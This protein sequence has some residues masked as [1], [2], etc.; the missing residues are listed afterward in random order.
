MDSY[1]SAKA[2]MHIH[3]IYSERPSEWI[4]K[5]LGT[6][7]SYTGP[8]ALYK[9]ARERGMDFVTITDHNKIDGVLLLQKKYPDRVFTGVEATTYFPED[10]C[11]IHILIYGFTEQQFEEIDKL[12]SDIYKL[13]EY[14]Y[15]NNLAYSVAH[16]SYAVNKKLT[17]EHIEKLFLMFDSFE[18]FNGSRA[19]RHTEIWMRIL[20]KLDPEVINTLIEKHGIKPYGKKP[21]E[22][23]HTGGTDDHSGLFPGSTYTSV[24]ADNKESFLEQIKAGAGTVHGRHNQYHFLAFS[25][26][27]I[28]YEYAKERG[29]K[30]PKNLLDNVHGVIFN[31]KKLKLGNKII[32]GKLKAGLRKKNEETEKYVVD[33]IIKSLQDPNL[34]LDEKLDTSYEAISIFSDRF[35]KSIIKSIKPNKLDLIGTVRKLSS[36]FFGLFLVLPF[37]STMKHMFQERQILEEMENKY[38]GEDHKKDKKILWFSDTLT[39]VNGVSFTLQKLAWLSFRQGRPLTLVSSLLESE[40]TVNLPP[41]VM[42]L[43]FIHHVVPSVYDHYAIKAPSI[44]KSL[45]MIHDADPDEIIISTPGPLGF[46]GLLAAK[47][48]SI[49]TKVIFHTDYTAELE[50]LMDDNSVSDIIDAFI[51]G[52]YNLNDEILITTNQYMKILSEKGFDKSKMKFFKRGL[53]LGQFY[54]RE[55]GRELINSK[56]NVGEGT[57]LLYT[58]RISK[59]KNLELLIEVFRKLRKRHPSLKLLMIGNGPDLKRMQQKNKNVKGLIF[60]GYQSQEILPEI[61]SG[62]DIFVFPSLTDTFGMSVLEAQACGLPAIVSDK[63]GPQE[64]IE[65]NK[66]GL[67]ASG[68]SADDW[69]NKISDMI[70]LK[71][72]GPDKFREMRNAAI[73]LVRKNHDWAVLLDQF[74]VKE[75]PTPTKSKKQKNR[76]PAMQS[77]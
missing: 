61:Y 74:F 41:N 71:D 64:I 65:E 38:V 12:R 75:T 67:I 35:L 66:T 21:W 25:F 58:G 51:K 37:F 72:E 49:K 11:K 70:K 44:L 47:L 5:T 13:R 52:F 62:C 2:D 63:G 57:V 16:A 20:G 28:G 69:F 3:S 76:E 27:K 42:L 55:S 54:C 32:I 46:I 56:F 29:I 33:A 18:A 43:P 17:I 8:E 34:S 36:S 68:S 4:L 14:I 48:M 19:K 24:Q 9:S 15:Q 1:Q 22:K 40:K 26:Y 23:G 50:D 6:R 77:A 60:G 30:L 73:D 39:Y 45:K 10:G 31:K 59:D 53:D 7:E